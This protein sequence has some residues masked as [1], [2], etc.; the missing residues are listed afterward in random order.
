MDT[1]HNIA[2]LNYQNWKR[3]VCEYLLYHYF[4]EESLSNSKSIIQAMEKYE[5]KETKTVEDAN[6]YMSLLNQLVHNSAL[7]YEKVQENL[8]N[9]EL[10]ESICEVKHIDLSEAAYKRWLETGEKIKL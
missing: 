9:E 10:I 1:I 8:E 6:E 4:R 5:K 7:I 3:S 2:N